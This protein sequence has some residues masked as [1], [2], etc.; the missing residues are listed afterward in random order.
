MTPSV[1]LSGCCPV[2]SRPDR[3]DLPDLA[4][5][6]RGY[7]QDMRKFL[8]TALIAACLSSLGLQA[9]EPTL[10][11]LSVNA[12]RLHQL[13]DRYAP[14]MTT[15]GL[16]R[17]TVRMPVYAYLVEPDVAN[18]RRTALNQCIAILQQNAIRTD[19][20]GPDLLPALEMLD[21]MLQV[22]PEFQ[23]DPGAAGEVVIEPTV[24]VPSG[25]IPPR[26]G[27]YEL[28]ASKTP[29]SVTVSR[30]PR[31]LTL[32]LPVYFYIINPDSVRRRA[33]AFHNIRN[34]VARLVG[35]PTV[36][37]EQLELVMLAAETL[38]KAEPEFAVAATPVSE[39][40]PNITP[41]R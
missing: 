20:R 26:I 14:S 17:V 29:K 4:A 2:C 7:N 39:V 16:N 8:T 40:Q 37:R 10:L 11:P 33:H 27:P 31:A 18:T 34:Q 12:Y 23:F 36:E 1:R 5:C 13:T 3:P 21:E 30:G 9:D 6:A 32:Q 19:V 25:Q 22:D 15:V 28:L 41:A 24:T 35:T 38:L